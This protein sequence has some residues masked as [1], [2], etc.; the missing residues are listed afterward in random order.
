LFSPTIPHN[1]IQEKYAKHK[2]KKTNITAD[3]LMN[4]LLD[5]LKK[6][7]RRDGASKRQSVPLVL[8][9]QGV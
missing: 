5:P 8:I 6:G 9:K 3:P 4:Y 2:K 7:E 1:I